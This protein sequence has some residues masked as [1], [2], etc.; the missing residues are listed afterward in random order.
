MSVVLIFGWCIF[1][2]QGGRSRCTTCQRAAPVLSLGMYPQSASKRPPGIWRDLFIC[3]AAVVVLTTSRPSQAGVEQP[4]Q[5]LQ[6]KIA[7]CLQ[8]L[9][10]PDQADRQQQEQQLWRLSQSIFDFQTMSRLVLAARWKVLNPAQRRA[11]TESFAAFLRHTYLPE[12]MVRYNGQQVVY[13]RQTMLSS[14]R[15][16]VLV[17]VIWNAAVIPVDISMVRRD[18]DW[19]VYDVRALGISAVENYRAQIDGLLQRE[20]LTQLL[21]RLNAKRPSRP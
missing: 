9:A 18:G 3:F 8:F 20:S 7:R 2:A 15:A 10:A 11:F 17:H 13:L 5:R 21:A 12:V 14:S 16:H 4:L 1:A 19:F 6:T